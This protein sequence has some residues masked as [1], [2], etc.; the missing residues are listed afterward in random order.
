MNDFYYYVSTKAGCDPVKTI[1]L[2]VPQKFAF[3][4]E[5]CEKFAEDS[6]WIKETEEDA[7]LLIVPCSSNWKKENKD[8]LFNI[9]QEN[10]NNF[11]A[12]SKETIPGRNG[13]VWTWETLIYLVGYED[14][15][16]FA[17]DV[18]IKHP[19]K[20]AANAI[21]DGTA[22]S[23]E[24]KEK[25]SDHWLVENP[26]D[27][28]KKNKEI[29]VSLWL[30][31]QFNKTDELQQYFSTVNNSTDSC[32]EVIDGIPTKTYFNDKNNAEVIR[33]SNA[34]DEKKIANTIM[35]TFFN[36]IIRWKNS[37]DGQLKYKMGKNDFY[38]LPKYL[39]HDLFID[40]NKYHYAVYLPKGYTKEMVKGFPVVFSIHGRGEP[41][42]IFAEKNGWEELADTTKEFIVVFPDSPQNIWTFERDRNVL[43]EIIH[44]IK[45]EYDIDEERIYI[46]GFSNGAIY[47][48][49]QASTYPYLFAAASPWNGP[50]IKACESIQSIGSY[51]YN[52]QF[53]NGEYEMPFYIIVGDNDKKAE[54]YREDELE[55]ALS[56]NKC[57]KESE[58]VLNGDN[59]YTNNRDYIEGDRLFTRLFA[60]DKNIQMVGLT[61]VKNMPHGA[62]SDESLASWEFMKKFKRNKNN[63][64]IELIMEKDNV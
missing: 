54:M 29:P 17:S 27:Y 46:T 59:Y 8:L 16:N 7:A 23:F 10:R 53:K 51:V 20:F 36:H 48:D 45:Q 30:F 4:R 9:Y 64:K 32:N 50:S 6:G 38:Q 22:S 1:F 18:L 42:W 19:N 58:K 12:P 34:Y 25:D 5:L 37:P 60:N 47:V 31:D 62:I 35:K 14:G 63:Q 40:N 21:V 3:N 49:Q 13:I 44:D 28:N 55:I 33:V 52:P 56:A 43:A 39:H 15:G 61:V 2:C 11:Y 57:N 24:V 41:T 26:S